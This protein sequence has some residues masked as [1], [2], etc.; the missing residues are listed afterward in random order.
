MQDIYKISDNKA[1]NNDKLTPLD[2]AGCET[3]VMLPEAG[4][5]DMTPLVS[6]AGSGFPSKVKFTNT[7]AKIFWIFHSIILDQEIQYYYLLHNLSLILNIGRT[8][9]LTYRD[10][11]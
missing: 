6:L 3:L 7:P 4:D 10:R 11:L 9:N 1:D 2:A 5:D 8:T